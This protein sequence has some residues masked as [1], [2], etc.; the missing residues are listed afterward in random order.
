[1][2]RLS[3]SLL[4]LAFLAV[5]TVAAAGEPAQPIGPEEAIQIALDNHPMLRAA[6]AEVRAAEADR[7]SANSGYMPHIQVTEDWIRS[8]NPVYVFSSKLLQGVFSPSDFDIQA[9][10]NPDPITN[11]QTGIS[12]YQNIWNAGRTRLHKKAATAGIAAAEQS[13]DTMRDEVVFGALK[14]FWDLVLAQEM[15]GVTR[16][17]EAA[18]RANLSLATEMVDAGLAVPSDRLSAEVR[19]AEVE[20]MRIRAEYGVDVA[21]AAL[22]GALGVERTQRFEPLPPRSAPV[23]GDDTLEQRIDRAYTDRSDLQT[24]DRRMDQAQFGVKMGRSGNLPEFGALGRYE[25]NGANLFGADGQNW[26]VGLSARWTI[27]DGN[28]TKGQS[29][30]ARADLARL[31]AMHAGLRQGINVQVQAAWADRESA[32]RRLHV[33]VAARSRAEEALR[34]VRERYGEGLAVIVE[35][36]GTEAA[37]TRAQANHAQAVSEL[38]LAEASLDLASGADPLVRQPS[39][40]NTDQS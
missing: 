11:S 29:A 33:A 22:L 31:E 23:P 20:A 34:I 12:I 15:L 35:L 37:F 27:F 18:A 19:M 32:R 6:E 3:A 17:A 36:L 9:L 5:G 24:L 28:R 16:A 4:I 26:A 14:S 8:D 38:W 40:N 1:M 25:L 21:H 30:R 39:N 7:Q 2:M 10:N 13:R